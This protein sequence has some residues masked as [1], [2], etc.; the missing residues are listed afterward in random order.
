VEVEQADAR[1]IVY[2]LKEII[3]VY[4]ERLTRLLVLL[5]ESHQF[6]SQAARILDPKKNRVK[7][8]N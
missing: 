1:E 3:L 7:Q 6:A 2:F 4:I 5:R 8:R